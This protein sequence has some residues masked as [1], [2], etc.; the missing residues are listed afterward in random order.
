MIHATTP[1]DDEV[2]RELAA[3][4]GRQENIKELLEKKRCLIAE[5][6]GPEDDLKP[7]A[8]ELRVACKRLL[9]LTQCGNTKMAFMRDTLAP[10]IKPRMKV[11]EELKCDIFRL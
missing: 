11:Y 9:G 3:S 4:A 5:T 10:L 7:L 1:F 6:E 2:L 8:G